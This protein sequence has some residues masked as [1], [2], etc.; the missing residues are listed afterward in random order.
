MKIG[1]D[2]RG[3]A[4]FEFCLVAVVFF[5]FVFAIFDLGRYAITMQSLRSLVSE[6]ARATM[7]QCYTPQ[8][9]QNASPSG[10]TDV[11]TYY[12]NTYLTSLAN[13]MGST[14]TLSATT[15]ASVLTITASLPNFAMLMPIWGTSL[16]SPS[17]S[18]SIPY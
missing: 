4:A 6:G 7:I 10:C 15:G 18:T 13:I 8:V 11:N 14:P 5:T 17:A 9:T 16:N 1:I 3:A 12:T 2:Q